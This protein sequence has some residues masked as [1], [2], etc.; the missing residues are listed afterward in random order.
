MPR[1]R[2]FISVVTTAAIFI[3][4]EVAALNMMSHSSEIQ[5]SWVGSMSQGVRSAFWGTGQ[6]IGGYFS[7]RKQNRELAEENFRLNQKLL[8]ASVVEDAPT[9]TIKAFEYTPAEIVKI[10][11]NR[12]HNYIILSKGF[13]DGIKEKSAVITRDGAI[14]IIDAVSAHFSYAYSFQNSDISISTRL[15]KEGAVGAMVW[16]GHSSDGAVLKEIP[17]QYHYEKGDTVYTSG[18]SSIFPPDIP[19]GV[20][21]DS[22]IINGSTN[23]IRIKLFRN[24]SALRYVTI[25]HNTRLDELEEFDK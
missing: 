15:G 8:E 2:R 14:G 23:E 22:K 16:D 5:R 3:A 12:Q 21:L 7:L 20:A 1:E 4:M 24:F 19:L 13:K 11:R 18:Y 17:L 6:K 10:S 25:V 9:K